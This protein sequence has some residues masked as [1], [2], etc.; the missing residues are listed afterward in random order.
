MALGA[1]H[2]SKFAALHQYWWRLHMSEKFSSRR[3]TTN[4]Q[5]IPYDISQKR[6]SS[7]QSSPVISTQGLFHRTVTRLRIS[8]IAMFL[9][10]EWWRDGAMAISGIT[11]L[12]FYH[13]KGTQRWDETRVESFP[14][15]IN[16]D[17][18]HW[19]NHYLYLFVKLWPVAPCP[20]TLSNEQ[21]CSYADF[22]RKRIF[23][24][25]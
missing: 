7:L 22:A 6:T 8:V 4:K 15:E 19:L 14:V 23:W 5:T 16:I 3:K 17:D 25:L 12:L 10:R 11:S 13:F 24:L 21:L 20:W 1:E 9:W 18:N 2:R